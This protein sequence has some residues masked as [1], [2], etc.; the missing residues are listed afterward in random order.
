MWLVGPAYSEVPERR[1]KVE[2]DRRWHIP[3]TGVQEITIKVT[4]SDT[5]TLAIPRTV[6]DW[7]PPGLSRSNLAGYVINLD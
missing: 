1:R 5:E 7:G 2:E 6:I 3:R 4:D